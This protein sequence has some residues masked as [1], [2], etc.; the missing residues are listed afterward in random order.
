MRGLKKGIITKWTYIEVMSCPG[1]CI[2]GGG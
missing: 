2:N 1:G